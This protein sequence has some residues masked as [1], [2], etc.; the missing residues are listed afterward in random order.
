MTFVPNSEKAVNGGDGDGGD[1]G[2][3]G[4][5]DAAAAHGD[6]VLEAALS[7]KAGEVGQV[8]PAPTSSLSAGEACRFFGLHA[9]LAEDPFGDDLLARG[10]R[11]EL[12]AVG[13]ETAQD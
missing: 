13:A 6:R 8:T 9:G 7:V 2:G 3:G 11:P 4:G 12:V 1:R 10:G 5:G